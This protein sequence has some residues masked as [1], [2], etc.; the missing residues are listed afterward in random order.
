MRYK[1][2]FKISACLKQLTAKQKYS[3]FCPDLASL[4][5][6][7]SH[8]MWVLVLLPLQSSGTLPQAPH[9]NQTLSSTLTGPADTF[10]LPSTY[11]NSKCARAEHCF[12]PSGTDSTL[13][14]DAPSRLSWV[15]PS[16]NPTPPAKQ[17]TCWDSLRWG[18]SR[19]APGLPPAL[20]LWLGFLFPDHGAAPWV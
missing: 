2:P 11:C 20:N 9:G 8:K 17:T 4:G 13:L 5:C 16:S 1:D 10:S 15:P 6:S 19:G 12:K 18:L 7:S 14:D 3:L